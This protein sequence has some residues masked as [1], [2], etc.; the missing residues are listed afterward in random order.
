M[1]SVECEYH[2]CEVSINKLLWT[3][4]KVIYCRTMCIS[5]SNM[6]VGQTSTCGLHGLQKP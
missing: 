2:A 3:L 1:I 5:V 4:R 6:I